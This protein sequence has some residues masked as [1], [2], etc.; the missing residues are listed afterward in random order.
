MIYLYIITIIKIEKF[1][2]PEKVSNFFSYIDKTNDKRYNFIRF[3]KG[4][5]LWKGLQ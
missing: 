1:K 2:V 5:E 4:G 3:V